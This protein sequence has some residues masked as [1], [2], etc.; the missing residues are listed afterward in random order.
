MEVGEDVEEEV[1]TPRRGK[2]VSQKATPAVVENKRKGTKRKN[3]DEPKKDGKKAKSDDDAY[4]IDNLD[5]HPEIGDS[6]KVERQSNGGA[7]FLATSNHRKGRFSEIEKAAKERN[8]ESPQGENEGGVGSTGKKSI[9]LLTL[10]DKRLVSQINDGDEN[11]DGGKESK[12]KL[13]KTLKPTKASTKSTPK[14]AA[15][16]PAAKTAPSSVKEADVSTFTI[17]EMTEDTQ[18]EAD[19]NFES[20]YVNQYARVYAFYSGICY[21]AVTTGKS[22]V[23]SFE[24]QFLDDK[25]MKYIARGGIYRL[26]ELA[27]GL[28][29]EFMDGENTFEG[30]IKTVP[31]STKASDFYKAKFVVER[32]DDDGKTSDVVVNWDKIILDKSVLKNLKNVEA[33]IKSLGKTPKKRN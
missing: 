4:N 21:A 22:T 10:N 24:V 20:G 12:K 17:P 28:E 6:F 13:P 1:K 18:F 7:K 26:Q 33:E 3:P 9:S 19:T 2:R 31:D 27:T 11:E 23:S 32:K 30:V 29:V 15:K 8:V 14:S 16:T 25:V 5:E